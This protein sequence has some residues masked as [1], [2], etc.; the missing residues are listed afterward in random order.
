MCCQGNCVAVM[1][2]LLRQMREYHYTEYIRQFDTPIDL[3]DFLMEI[4]LVF[5]DLISRNVHP[6]DWSEMIML[7]NRWAT[8]GKYKHFAL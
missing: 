8:C 3:L 1:T 6:P 4:L 5:Q 2:S 7:Q